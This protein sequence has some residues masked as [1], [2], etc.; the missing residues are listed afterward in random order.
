MMFQELWT[1]GR[2]AVMTFSPAMSVTPKFGPYVG[3]AEAPKLRSLSLEALERKFLI[4]WSPGAPH[5]RGI[6][7]FSFYS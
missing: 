4:F 3:V 7:F 6:L 2:G 1:T 5:P